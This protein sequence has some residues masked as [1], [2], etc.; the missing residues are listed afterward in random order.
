MGCQGK[1]IQEGVSSIRLRLPPLPQGSQHHVLKDKGRILSQ[2]CL[3]TH[4]IFWKS[5]SI[6]LHQRPQEEDSTWLSCFLWNCGVAGLNV[7]V[8]SKTRK[9][10]KHKEG[11]GTITHVSPLF[12]STFSQCAPR[13]L[14]FSFLLLSLHILSYS[15]SVIMKYSLKISFYDRTIF[16]RL[17]KPQASLPFPYQ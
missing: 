17:A 16:H 10:E 14:D 9:I 4:V 13:A 5:Q 6:W 1:N 2:K 3:A 7:R 11:F 15:C 8:Y 12:H